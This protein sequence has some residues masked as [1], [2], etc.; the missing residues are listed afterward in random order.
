V[1]AEQAVSERLGGAPQL[2]PGQGNR[3]GRGLDRYHLPVPV[4]APGPGILGA[5]GPGVPV[6]AE[7]LGDL[8]FQRGL[9]QQLRA[10]PR[11]LL[12]GAASPERIARRCGHGYGR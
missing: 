6:T 9:H 2:R 3:P 8:C 1:R 12:Q 4:T 5:R 7:E 11:D 10:E